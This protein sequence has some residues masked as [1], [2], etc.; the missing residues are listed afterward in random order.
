MEVRTKL[1]VTHVR[2]VPDFHVRTSMS[3]YIE[4]TFYFEGKHEK[5]FRVFFQIFYLQIDRRS[6]LCH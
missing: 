4:S 5:L 2:D 6:R 3:G 1:Q